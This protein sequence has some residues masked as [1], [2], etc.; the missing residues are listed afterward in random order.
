MVAVGTWLKNK[1]TGEAVKVVEAG[2]FVR[3]QNDD[4]DGEVQAAKLEELFD[5]LSDPSTQEDIEAILK[6]KVEMGEA[7]TGLYDTGLCYVVVDRVDDKVTFQWFGHA[8]N[9]S[10]ALN[11][12]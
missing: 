6:A 3:Y 4:V 7:E 2:S 12:D 9:I 5:I 1:E 8:M 11:C 10:D